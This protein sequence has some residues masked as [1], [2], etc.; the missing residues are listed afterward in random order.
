MGGWL[1]GCVKR[2]LFKNNISVR[3]HSIV[4]TDTLHS[5]TP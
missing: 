2:S 1:G 5:A 4:D 3:F